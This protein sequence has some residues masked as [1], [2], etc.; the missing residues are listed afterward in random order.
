MAEGSQTLTTYYAKRIMGDTAAAIASKALLQTGE[1]IAS[2][3]WILHR[4]DRNTQ[5]YGIKYKYGDTV[6]TVNDGHDKIE[7]YGASTAVE[8]SATPSAWV[9]LD[10]GDAYFMGSVG[11]GTDTLS[12]K[13]SVNGTSYFSDVVNIANKSISSTQGSGSL[14]IG[15][16]SGKNISIDEDEIIARDYASNAV[17]ASNLKLNVETASTT[18]HLSTITMGNSGDNSGYVSIQYTNDCTS[19]STGALR[20][21]GGLYVTKQIRTSDDLTIYTQFNRANVTGLSA[22]AI[23]KIDFISSDNKTFA[24]LAAEKIYTASGL[25]V[26]NLNKVYISV[27]NSN[28]TDNETAF[29]LNAPPSNATNTNA[30]ISWTDHYVGHEILPY[31]HNSYNIG[32]ANYRWKYGYF[33]TNLFIG[34]TTYTNSSQGVVGTSIGAGSITLVGD[35]TPEINFKYNKS[36]SVT[37]YIN[38]IDGAVKIGPK[39]VVN[40]DET[41]FTLNGRTAASSFTAAVYGNLFAT[42]PIYSNTGFYVYRSSSGGGIRIYQ[43]DGADSQQQYGA[44]YIDTLGATNAEGS[45]ILLLGNDKKY[46]GDT[47][48]DKNASGLMRLYNCNGGY[49][50]FSGKYGTLSG[51][52]RSYIQTDYI[53]SSTIF[54]RIGRLRTTAPDSSESGNS[55]VFVDN[56][57]ANDGLAAAES[58]GVITAFINS[59]SNHG[60][61]LRVY[62]DA[63]TGTQKSF[64][65][66]NPSSTNGS[67]TNKN[68][69]IAWDNG[70]INNSIYPYTDGDKNIGSFDYRWLNIRLAGA[71]SYQT[72]TLTKGTQAN[73]SNSTYIDTFYSYEKEGTA[74]K[75][76]IVDE[77]TEITKGNTVYHYIRTYSWKANST[78]RAYLRLGATNAESPVYELYTNGNVF[79]QRNIYSGDSTEIVQRV[80]SVRSNSGALT[81]YSSGNETSDGWR[82]LWADKKGTDGLAFSIISVDTNSNTT[83]NLYNSTVKKT[84][85]VVA[86]SSTPSG[87]TAGNRTWTIPMA[88]GNRTFV[89]VRTSDDY[90]FN[91][92][93]IF[94]AGGT[95]YACSAVHSQILEQYLISSNRN[96]TSVDVRA[97]GLLIYGTCYGNDAAPLLS[98]TDGLIRFGDGGPQIIFASGASPFGSSPSQAGALIFTD[99]NDAGGQASFHFVTNQSPDNQG[100]SLV[101][102]APMIWARKSIKITNTN[103]ADHIEFSRTTYNYISIPATNGAELCIGAV[104]STINNSIA[105]FSYNSTV[106]SRTT[107]LNGELYTTSNIHSGGHIYLAA[108][109]DIF[110]AYNNTDYPILENFN[111]KNIVFNAATGGLYLGYKN[112]TGIYMYYSTDASTRTQYF[113]INNNGSYANTRFGVNGQN[114]SYT[115]YVNGSTLHNGTVYFANGTTYYID[116]SAKAYFGETRV[117]YLTVNAAHQTTYRAY[118]NGTLLVRGTSYINVGGDGVDITKSNNAAA[119]NGITANTNRPL[120]W[121]DANGKYIGRVYARADTNGN[122]NIFIQAGNWYGDTPAQQAAGIGITL[123][124]AGT[125]TCSI[126]GATTIS[127]TV[128]ATSN[129][130]SKHSTIDLKSSTNGLT[131]NA[132]RYFEAVDKNGYGFALFQGV[133]KTDGSIYVYMGVNNRK[134]DGTALGWHGISITQTKSS[135]DVTYGV[136]NAANFRSAI[137]LGTA[138]THAHSDYALASHGNHVPTTATA[139]NLKFLRCDNSWYKLTKTETSSLLNMLDTATANVNADCYIITCEATNSSTTYYRRGASKIVNATLVKAALGT[140]S[141]TAKKFLKDTGSF[142]QVDWGDLTGKP[143]T[144]APSSHSHTGLVHRTSLAKGSNPS[145]T[146]WTLGSWGYETGTGAEVANRL[147]GLEGYINT[148]GRTAMRLIAYKNEASSTDTN[149]LGCWIDKNGTM[150]YTVS[151]PSAFRSAIE[152]GTAATHAHGDYATSGHTHGWAN[153]TDNANSLSAGTSDLC[154]GAE[155][156]TSYASSNGF[157][158]TNAKGKVYRRNVTTMYNYIKSKASGSWGISVTGSAG[159][160]AWANTGHP[161]TF[162][163]SSHDHTRCGTTATWLYFNNANEVNF[164]GTDTNKTIYFGY[165]ATDSRPM[166]TAYSFG[167][168]GAY[169]TIYCSSV[170]AD[171]V[172]SLDGNGLLAY[173]PASWSWVSN[174]QWGVGA[175]NCQGV[176]RSNNNHLVHAK[177]GTNYNILDAS[178]YT[179]YTVKKDGTGASGS[180]GI[181]V[182]GS[183]GSCTGNAASA[184]TAKEVSWQSTADCSTSN[185]G[186]ANVDRVPVWSG[187]KNGNG[188]MRLRTYIYGTGDNAGQ[189]LGQFVVRN[190]N[191]STSAWGGWGGISIYA[192]KDGTFDY[193]VSSSANFRSAIGVGAS[194]THADSYF[195]YASGETR[196]F[197]TTGNVYAHRV[198]ANQGT[199]ETRLAVDHT[200]AGNLY[201]WSNSTGKG[202]YSGSGYKTGAIIKIDGS[203]VGFYGELSGNATGVS[204][205]GNAVV[206]TTNSSTFAQLQTATRV[207]RLQADGNLVVYEGSTPKWSAGTGSSRLIKQNIYTISDS[208]INKFMKIRPVSFIYRPEMGYENILRYGVIAEELLLVYPNLVDIPD[209][210]SNETFDIKKGMEQPLITVKYD[211]FIPLLIKMVQ[212]Q[213]REI[214]QLRNQINKRD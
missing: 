13:L 69:Y 11:I 209:N 134:T 151:S 179:S 77:F 92:N 207:L 212:N 76:R 54:V 205:S 40:S 160:V 45:T 67:I 131:S 114:T 152:L 86:D 147:T 5:L 167:K 102:T 112:T 17:V 88:A 165:R 9:Q 26:Q 115:L 111:N 173:K 193:G 210:Y 106:N 186:G 110:M 19:T 10:T 127:G 25:A 168:S 135:A 108:D 79:A 137:G 203:T 20:V 143:S 103:A 206:R 32:N 202:L 128:T 66:I 52:A 49:G 178:N 192:K 213:Q 75:N 82:G 169:A 70:Y 123:S 129:F 161:S 185:N 68:G 84:T 12:Y 63:N 188:I 104:G 1:N 39:L 7:F 132:D 194:G 27:Y 48:Q 56:K 138:A 43:G 53:S 37:S 62:N 117:T 149:Q 211:Q 157:A 133:A 22:D 57:T 201:L 208:E 31:T 153:L 158:D 90:P 81:L 35:T 28:N 148:S 126:G 30:Y 60:L 159:S 93:G 124:K 71:V 191:T 100:G 94:Y 146:I 142:V 141:T 180:W 2:D 6:N 59:S 64:S 16:I 97:N 24:R 197:T 136:S 199:E 172:N 42:N 83:F 99:H 177:A 181:S 164:G 182:T 96:S 73:A 33:T 120:L 200:T 101:V 51:T 125:M 18:G 174:S 175:T 44:L 145:S 98:N 3:T 36:T 87:V 130:L 91:T 8:S 190:Y 41:T 29:T 74:E 23:R 183:S 58:I 105:R 65:F 195:V 34:A 14:I 156:L 4:T 80:I 154:D 166:P 139:D 144:F 50:Y 89:G 189:V 118:I 72:K 162:P 163:P 150:G 187:E 95:T 107:S 122:C 116:N 46:I 55:I 47:K 214:E 113:T 204:T 171:I 184:T 15:S 109:K 61:R 78:E 38:G 176:I 85:S 155:I 198:W 121:T 21:G 170:N 119:T 140:V 196:N